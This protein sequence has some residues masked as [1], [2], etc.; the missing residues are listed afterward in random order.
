MSTAIATVVAMLESLPAPAQEQVVEHL[1]EYVEELR[2][3]LKWDTLVAKTQRQLVAAARRAKEE[4]ASGK[5][6]PLDENKL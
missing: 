2:D 3:E 5:S 6:E 4:I 1:R